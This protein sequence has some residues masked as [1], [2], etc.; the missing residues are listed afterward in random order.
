MVVV[1]EERE[2]GMAWTALRA[3]GFHRFGPDV[4][5]ATVPVHV[6]DG[7]STATPEMK[8]PA[9]ATHPMNASLRRR[10]QKGPEGR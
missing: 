10:D 5:L 3:A 8:G 9:L 4:A 7:R 6:S 1:V 2:E